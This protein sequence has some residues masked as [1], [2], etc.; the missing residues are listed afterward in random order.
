MLD[1]FPVN[2]VKPKVKDCVGASPRTPGKHDALNAYLGKQVGVAS[3]LLNSN[4]IFH[5]VDCT[6]GSG[7]C[8]NYSKTTSPEIIEKHADWLRSRN[9]NVN[10]SFYERSPVNASK[11][12][13]KT[14]YPVYAQDAKNVPVCWSERDFL[15]VVND[16]NTMQDWV[17][18][19][20][21]KYAPKMTTI[22]STMGC[23]VGGI[24]RLDY[25][26]R[27]VWYHHLEGQL[28][29]LRRWHDALIVT[30]EGD[31]AQWAY[32]VNAPDKWRDDVEKNFN[33]AFKK[34]NHTLKS[35]WYY[36]DRVDF[37]NIV[38]YLFKTHKER[39]NDV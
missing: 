32:L 38:N 23:N 39:L 1:F 20:S 10:V 25:K 21:L 11:L 30:L 29:L 36:K 35:A 13:A 7:E 31:A 16:P 24:K 5:I 4:Q 19:E 12:K 27:Q 37:N 26:Y 28:R 34:C 18:P 33:K 9:K 8:S 6:A 22:F 15:F 3:R 2:Q 14:K 17:L